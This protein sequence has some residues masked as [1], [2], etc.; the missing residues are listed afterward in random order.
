[1]HGIW[2]PRGLNFCVNKLQNLEHLPN[3]GPFIIQERRFHVPEMRLNH[4]RPSGHLPRKAKSV[5]E[6]GS[7]QPMIF[8]MVTRT[9]FSS[10]AMPMQHM[11]RPGK[12]TASVLSQ[13]KT[14]RQMM[15]QCT[16]VRKIR[17]LQNYPHLLLIQASAV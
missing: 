11:T 4:T 17:R 3:F 10:Y 16:R 6:V 7:L 14:T 2:V 12:S 9:P 1:L 15:I 5:T 13:P 8:L